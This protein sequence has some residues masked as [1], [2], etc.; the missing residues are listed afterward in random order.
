MGKNILF[1]KIE[2]F[3]RKFYLNRLI[4]GALIGSVLMIVFFLIFNGIEYFSWLPQKGRLILL[5]LFICISAFVIATFFAI[6]IVNLLRSE[7]RCPTVTG[8]F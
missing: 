8:R 1:E 4:Q 2:R 6:P 7:R 5:V 3:I